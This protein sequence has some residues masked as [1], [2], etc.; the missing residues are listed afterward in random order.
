[1]S[2]TVTVGFLLRVQKQPTSVILGPINKPINTQISV[3][4]LNKEPHTKWMKW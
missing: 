3:I 4:R 1:M 2:D